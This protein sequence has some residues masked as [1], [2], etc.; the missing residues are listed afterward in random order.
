VWK[1]S[2]EDIFSRKSCIDQ[3]CLLAK[4][5]RQF[6]R[7]V[8]PNIM[9]Q[10]DGPT[11]T[12]PWHRVASIIINQCYH[13]FPVEGTLYLRGM[14]NLTWG[15]IWVL[16]KINQGDIMPSIELMQKLE[17]H[18]CVLDLQ[19]ENPRP[20]LFFGWVT[21]SH[22]I[23]EFRW[24]DSMLPPQRQYLLMW[25]MVF[26]TPLVLLELKFEHG[27]ICIDMSLCLL[28]LECIY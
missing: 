17:K 13:V 10:E 21:F 1:L 12:N 23:R 4:D 7:E 2:S 24:A 5:N 6:E 15:I 25:L 28:H 16:D 9:P 3:L 19:V 27:I 11:I 20:P 8:V 26:V 14:T 22:A 18:I